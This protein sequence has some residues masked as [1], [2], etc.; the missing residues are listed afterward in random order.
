MTQ[1][2]KNKT[3]ILF[4][5]LIVIGGLVLFGKDKPSNTLL[6]KYGIIR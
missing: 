4:I 1:R 3:I 5:I 2:E 6:E